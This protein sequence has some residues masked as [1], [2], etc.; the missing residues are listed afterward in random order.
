MYICGVCGICLCIQAWGRVCCPTLCPISVCFFLWGS[1]SHRTWSQQA[2]VMLL[3]L[4]PQDW[5]HRCSQPHLTFCFALYVSSEDAKSGPS[6]LLKYLPRALKRC[7]TP[8]LPDVE[9]RARA[10]LT[11]AGHRSDKGRLLPFLTAHFCIACIHTVC[12]SSKRNITAG[13]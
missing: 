1:V 2:P 10:L 8:A 3:P 9:R 11:T 6:C 13:W 4:S 7:F 5:G 12:T